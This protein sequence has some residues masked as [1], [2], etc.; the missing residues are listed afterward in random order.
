MIVLPLVLA[1]AF[2]RFG[3]VRFVL[4]SFAFALVLAAAFAALAVIRD[5]GWLFRLLPVAVLVGAVASILLSASAAFAVRLKA[6]AAAS[7]SGLVFLAFLPAVGNYYLADALA[8]G[9]TVPW[10][11]VGCA[12]LAALPAVLLFL[13]LGIHFINGRDVS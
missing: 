11:Y 8:R 4:S 3:N 7:V 13:L 5:A 12:A 2:N 9:G 6:N 1:A 10:A